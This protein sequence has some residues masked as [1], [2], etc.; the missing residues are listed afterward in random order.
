[1][2][3]FLEAINSFV[4]KKIAIIIK[5]VYSSKFSFFQNDII[6]DIIYKYYII[7]DKSKKWDKKNQRFKQ[8]N[9]K[10]NEIEEFFEKCKLFFLFQ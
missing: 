9:V 8:K 10:N 5:I 1:M 4:I 6:N 3:K 7:S 2:Q